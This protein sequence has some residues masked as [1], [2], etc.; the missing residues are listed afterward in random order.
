MTPLKVS[1][2]LVS[3]NLASKNLAARRDDV[4]FSSLSCGPRR[5]SGGFLVAQAGAVSIGGRAEP[6]QLR[7]D[8]GSTLA[9][10]LSNLPAST[11]FGGGGPR[12]LR[13]AQIVCAAQ[14]M[15]D[16]TVRRFGIGGE[17]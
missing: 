6:S 4:I 12:D 14:K 3:K 1:K 8:F 9:T 17:K 13:D 10:M 5:S 16:F 7:S 2:N 15:L 11:Q